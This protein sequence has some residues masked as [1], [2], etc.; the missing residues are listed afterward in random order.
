MGVLVWMVWVSSLVSDLRAFKVVHGASPGL[1][2]GRVHV[3]TVY[4]VY[5]VSSECEVGHYKVTVGKHSL[6]FV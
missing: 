5:S 2:L 6:T 4:E 3:G 1:P